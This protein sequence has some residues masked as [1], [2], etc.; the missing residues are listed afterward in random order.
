MRNVP[1][2]IE[3]KT[4]ECDESALSSADTPIARDAPDWDRCDSD[5]SSAASVIRGRLTLKATE[6]HRGV[7][8]VA[9]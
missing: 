7:R 1:Q 6:G 8:V 9:P 4:F 3:D 2:W 5:L